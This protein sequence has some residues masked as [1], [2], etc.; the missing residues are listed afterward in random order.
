[1]KNEIDWMGLWYKIIKERGENDE[2]TFGRYDLSTKKVDW[3]RFSHMDMDG[4]GVLNHLYQKRGIQL[5]K[6]P[7]LKEKKYPNF[8]EAL[9][10]FIKLAFKNKKIKTEWMERNEGLAPKDVH[11][12]S[13][14]IFNPDQTKAIEEFS[15]NN[16]VSVCALLMNRSSK[17]LLQNL[18][19]NQEGTWTLPVNLRPILK[20]ENFNANHS[21]GILIPIKKND[22]ITDTNTQIKNSLKN[23]EHWA[24]WWIHQIGRVIGYS[25]MKYISNKN[26]QK[27]F[28]LGS[29]SYLSK[30]DIPSPDIYVGGPPGSKNFPVSVMVMLANGH[31]SYSL[32]IHPYILKDESKVE[33]YLNAI[34]H[35]VLNFV[36]KKS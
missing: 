25:G 15:K 32:K 10:I 34:V 29:F 11:K 28:M 33:E 31:M 19:F 26:A 22:Q 9:L 20:K 1:M 2:P 27:S 18:S 24:I 23:K 35:D 8:F 14:Y 17:V 6:F 21:S 30:W 4:V 36:S 12:I 5:T 7:D 16:N 3:F 13:Y